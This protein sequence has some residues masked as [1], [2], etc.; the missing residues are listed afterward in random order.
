MNMRVCRRLTFGDRR[1]LSVHLQDVVIAL[2]RKAQDE[3][4]RKAQP[5]PPWLHSGST[6][7]TSQAAAE[8]NLSPKRRSTPAPGPSPVVGTVAAVATGVCDVQYPPS[9]V[10]MDRTNAMD[11][12]ASG[13]A[14]LLAMEKLKKLKELLDM[15]ALTQE[16]YDAQKQGLLVAMVGAA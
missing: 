11:V 14:Q 9:E 13:D 10:V 15:G 4:A 5:S 3:A 12:A 6:Q 16:E 8:H 1:L 2:I 7:S